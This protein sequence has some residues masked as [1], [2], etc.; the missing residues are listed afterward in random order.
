M[1]FRYGEYPHTKRVS[2]VGPGCC[3]PGHIAGEYLPF[4]HTSIRNGAPAR[5]FMAKGLGVPGIRGHFVGCVR[6]SATGGVGERR[7]DAN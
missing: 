3:D 2:N 1:G 4:R 6:E 7:T 5:V